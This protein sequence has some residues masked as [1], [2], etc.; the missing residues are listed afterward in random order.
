MTDLHLPDGRILEYVTA[1]PADGFPLVL[2]HG[3]PSVALLYPALTETADRHGLRLVMHSRP[4][5]AGS[6]PQ[7]GRTVAGDGELTG[8]GTPAVP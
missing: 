7:P 4:G 1:G 2:H 3:T 6:S 5:Y 8:R